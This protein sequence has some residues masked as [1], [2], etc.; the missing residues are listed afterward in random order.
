MISSLASYVRHIPPFFLVPH[1]ETLLGCTELSG[2]SP[3]T[4]PYRRLLDLSAKPL[5]D[6]C[7]RQLIYRQWPSELLY[8]SDNLT[9]LFQTG[10]GS[11]RL[12]EESLLFTT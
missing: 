9:T 2:N 8:E 6:T 3:L 12:L 7:Y 4:L 11:S 1:P 5:I 10:G